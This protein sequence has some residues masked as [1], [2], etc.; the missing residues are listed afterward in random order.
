HTNNTANCD[1]GNGCTTTD[2][3]NNGTCGGSGNACGAIATGCT[4]CNGS[5]P[6]AG[7]YEPTPPQG[8]DCTCPATSSGTPVIEQNGMCVL[9]TD[10]C[11]SNPCGPL[12]IGCLDPTPAVAA[13]KDYQCTCGT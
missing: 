4:P 12:A 13:A 2:K 5:P 7:C 1:A 11:A 10:E 9:N 3:C 8:R 6:P